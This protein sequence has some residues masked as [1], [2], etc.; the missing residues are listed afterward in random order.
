MAEGRLLGEA[1]GDFQ[2]IRRKFYDERSRI[3]EEMDMDPED[4]PLEGTRD[5]WMWSYRQL[6]DQALDKK[7]EFDHET[8]A[9][10][11]ATL[12]DDW[13]TSGQGDAWEYVQDQQHLIEMKYPKKIKDM[14]EH[15][16]KISDSGWWDIADPVN[17]KPAMIERYPSLSGYMNELNTFLDTDKVHWEDLTTGSS[18]KNQIYRSIEKMRS[19]VVGPSGKIGKQKEAFLLQNPDIGDLLDLY[20]FSAPGKQYRE[21]NRQM[22]LLVAP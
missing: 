13:R 6:F 1:Y 3:F 16:R 7:G 4:E 11:L 17:V 2:D 20:G 18:R 22:Q 9:V 5:H 10:L 8:F 19:A 14:S 12:K 21:R 15:I